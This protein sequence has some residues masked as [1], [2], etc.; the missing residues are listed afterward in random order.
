[1]SSPE[2]T[3]VVLAL[4]ADHFRLQSDGLTSLKRYVGDALSGIEIRKHY[5]FD[6]L[7]FH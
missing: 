1:M 4:N 2:P 7:C 6:L 5:P 3:R